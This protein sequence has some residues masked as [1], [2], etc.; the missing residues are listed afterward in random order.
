MQTCVH[1]QQKFTVDLVKQ[2]EIFKA[3]HFFNP[4]KIYK[5]QP[6]CM[7]LETL[8]VCPFLNYNL[9]LLL[10]LKSE[11]PTYLSMTEDTTPEMD[12]IT[13]WKRYEHDVP[14]WSTAGRSILTIQP[15]S[16]SAERVFSLLQNI[17][18]PSQSSSLE[19]Y[20]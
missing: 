5:M 17:I 11:L 9:S 20:I 10:S 18:S 14:Y 3:V 13:W 6:T 12:V 4:L 1:N 19:D 7:D 16:A 15:S 2:V 8:S